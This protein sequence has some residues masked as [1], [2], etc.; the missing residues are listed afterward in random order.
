MK[1]RITT[2]VAEHRMLN[3]GVPYF[4]LRSSAPIHKEKIQTL[5]ILFD[6]KL[7]ISLKR[8]IFF[9]VSFSS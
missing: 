7:H 9:F 6:G 1:E 4:D 8:L 3:V 2:P 5:S